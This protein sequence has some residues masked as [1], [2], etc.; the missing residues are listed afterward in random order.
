MPFL[1]GEQ[2]VGIGGSADFGRGDLIATSGTLPTNRDSGTIADWTI[3]AAQS[4]V[5]ELET[6]SATE[7]Y[8]QHRISA[9]SRI[10]DDQFPPGTDGF[11]VV[12]TR[13]GNE[14]E[15]FAPVN[16][17]SAGGSQNTLVLMPNV[18]DSAAAFLQFTYATHIESNTVYVR[19]SVSFVAGDNAPS[20]TTV[21]IHYSGTGRRGRTGAQGPMRAM[22][23][24][25]QCWL[26]VTDGERRVVHQVAD[27]T[28]RRRHAKPATGQY[29]WRKRF[30]NGYRRRN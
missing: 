14:I 4:S 26:G 2:G 10:A 27:W 21:A 29:I 19:I 7:V 12:V 28:R 18:Q 13:D 15:T 24:G 20:A 8:L 23:A 1:P 9:N 30:R 6:V 16:F 5:W 25:R 22:R 3:D 17:G 11:S